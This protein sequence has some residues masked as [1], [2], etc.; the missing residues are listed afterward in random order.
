MAILLIHSTQRL[1]DVD[2]REEKVLLTAL[3]ALPTKGLRAELM[4]EH[5]LAP[6]DAV[7]DARDS[8]T[9]PRR[10]LSLVTFERALLVYLTQSG[11]RLAR[12]LAS[13]PASFAHLVSAHGAVT[14]LQKDLV[15]SLTAALP[16]P[17]LETLYKTKVLDQ[18]A[19]F[20]AYANAVAE[21]RTHPRT[22]T[23]T[24]TLTHLHTHSRTP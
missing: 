5:L 22:R 3:A 14:E 7:G 16:S 21:V 12:A 8:L 24:V 18:T 19:L 17:D 2:G 13:Q 1:Y 20:A 15:Q 6:P 9:L 4:D 23:H 10:L 11:P